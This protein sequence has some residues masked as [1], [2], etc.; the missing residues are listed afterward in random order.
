M[1]RLYLEVYEHG[2]GG[3]A[4][5]VLCGEEFEED[6]DAVALIGVEAGEGDNYGDV[7][8]RCYASTGV[9]AERTREHAKRLREEADYLDKL[10]GEVLRIAPA[11]W[12]TVEGV[13]HLHAQRMRKVRLEA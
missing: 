5:C 7:C 13:E 1:D 11:D 8:P 12:V 4:T 2:W 10:A 6:L 9:A 3:S